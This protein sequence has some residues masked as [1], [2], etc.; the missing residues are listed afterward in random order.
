MQCSA[1]VQYAK[2]WPHSDIKS[3]YRQSAHVFTSRYDSTLLGHAFFT[4]KV[5]CMRYIYVCTYVGDLYV[6]LLIINTTSYSFAT[7]INM[8]KINTL[9]LVV[10]LLISGKKLIATSD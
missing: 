8:T 9:A 6:S 3:C 5:F 4:P 1:C 10:H 2:P 7:G